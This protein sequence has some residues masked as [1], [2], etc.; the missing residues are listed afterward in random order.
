[1]KL[2]EPLLSVFLDLVL[3]AVVFFRRFFY[4][5][6]IIQSVDIDALA[7]GVFVRRSLDLDLIFMR[8]TLRSLTCLK[9]IM[10]LLSKLI[11]LFIRMETLL[12][13]SPGITLIATSLDFEL[14]ILQVLAP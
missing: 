14:W 9:I 11:K 5:F 6:I 3:L 8:N 7:A 13:N 10:I 1:M 4:L 2:P 12:W